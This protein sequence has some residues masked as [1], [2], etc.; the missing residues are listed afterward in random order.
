MLQLWVDAK[1]GSKYK[2]Q[3]IIFW[4]VDPA[5]VFAAEASGSKRKTQNSFELYFGLPGRFICI[6]K[7]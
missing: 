2:R 7:T 5:N 1:G 4:L 6:A 3:T